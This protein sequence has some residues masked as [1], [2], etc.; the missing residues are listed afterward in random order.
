M[1]QTTANL[2]DGVF[3]GSYP[4]YAPLL[5]LSVCPRMATLT[6]IWIDLVWYGDGM[7]SDHSLDAPIY[8]LSAGDDLLHQ[9]Q[10]RGRATELSPGDQ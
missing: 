8:L 7:Y 3:H 6:V 1:L 10:H 4:G 2:D 5:W 9:P